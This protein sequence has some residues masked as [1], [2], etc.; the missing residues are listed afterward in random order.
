MQARRKEGE[1]EGRF[2]LSF[3]GGTFPEPSWI[4][5]KKQSLFCAMYKTPHLSR[6]C[7]VHWNLKRTSDLQI[8]LTPARLLRTPIN[9]YFYFN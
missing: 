5:S 7:A 6:V 4:S 9:I 1:K 3:S 2:I 8:S